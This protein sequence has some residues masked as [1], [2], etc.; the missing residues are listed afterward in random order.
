VPHDLAQFLL[1]AVLAA[2][3]LVILF[4]L[5]IYLVHKLFFFDWPPLYEWQQARRQLRRIDR[6]RVI[7]ATYRRHP[8]SR[9]A[10]ADA[11]LAH[12]RYRQAAAQRPLGRQRPGWRTVA[13]VY[14]GV[15]AAFWA[16]LAA[17]H[18]QQRILS[19]IQAASFAGLALVN[20][21]GPRTARRQ[22]ELMARLQ[23][24][25]DDRYTRQRDAAPAQ[26][27]EPGLPHSA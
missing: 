1:V 9:H 5:G 6:W 11:Q 18:G 22:A 7:W 10:L 26:P 8:A 3:G 23:T 20:W 13:T 12:A 24:E 15:L 2:V 21:L 17:T 14:C 4:P 16:A 27:Q 19:I 25:I